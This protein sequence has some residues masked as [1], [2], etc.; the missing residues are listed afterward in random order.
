MFSHGNKK[1][2]FTDRVHL[3]PLL[4]GCDAQHR[5][6][7]PYSRF[8]VDEGCVP[9]TPHLYLPLFIS[10]ETERDL[11]M[12]VGLRLMDKCSELWVCG[13]RIS[14]GMRRE[15]AYA[16]EAGIQIR[17]VKEEAINVCS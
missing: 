12:S 1:Q 17:V 7:L 3:L 10:E 16:V 5:N 4:R 8:A 13:D 6:G 15:I 11:A 14:D 9:I 2:R